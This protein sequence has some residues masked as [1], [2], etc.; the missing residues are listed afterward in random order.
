[1][2]IAVPVR[3]DKGWD[4]LIDER[5]GRGAFFAIYDTDKDSLEIIENTAKDVASGAGRQAVQ[6]L[7]DNNVDVVIAY[8]VGPKSKD[9]L[10]AL[11]IDAY[12]LDNFNMSVKEVIDLYNNN[13]L[14]KV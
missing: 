11:G 2:R 1:M 10:D 13:K 5:F 6:L 14:Q 3:E 9:T 8:E 7:S 12:K 4:S